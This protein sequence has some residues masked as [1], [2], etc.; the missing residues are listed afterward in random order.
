MEIFIPILLL[1]APILIAN[2]I[3]AGEK[4]SNATI[5]EIIIAVVNIPLFLI[6]L[7]FLFIPSEITTL[8]DEMGFP[9]MDWAAAGWVLI[10]MALWA[11]LACI[12]PLRVLLGRLIPIDPASPVHT[13]VLILG[14]YL[15]GNTL[16]ALSQEVL[17]DI[18]Q[19]ELTVT[20]IDIVLQ[21]LAFVVVAFTGAG[22]LTRRNLQQVAQRL[23]LV[24]PNL[25]QLLWGVVVII[26]LIGIQWAIG[27]IWVLADPEQAAELG[28]INDLLLGNVDT[29]GEWFVLAIASGVGEE[30]LF[31]GALQPVLGITTTSL[32]FAI[33]HVQYGLTP[34]TGA[35]FIIG[36]ILG[37]LRRKTNTTTTIFVHF[38]Y[39]LIL[40]LF[41]LLA[42]Y[43][44]QLVG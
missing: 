29:I 27:I 22:L 7:L 23:G 3:A 40:G 13:L 20:I 11:I 44:Q 35:V 38:S 8:L 18:S 14:G 25:E 16:L 21:Q 32:L 6:G 41:A 39:N 42:S 30:I 33:V 12:R 17:L 4:K 36:L 43:V 37:I 1:L 15:I 26:L 5:F 28:E 9:I 31:R 10:F 34:I 19:A 2:L 24:R